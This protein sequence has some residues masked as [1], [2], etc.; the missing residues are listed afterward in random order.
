MYNP[1]RLRTRTYETEV[2]AQT[3]GEGT[4]HACARN[5]DTDAGAGVAANGDETELLGDDPPVETFEAG[6]ER[7][8]VVVYV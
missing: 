8:V 2:E 6:V 3:P 4:D 5:A 7:D 1:H